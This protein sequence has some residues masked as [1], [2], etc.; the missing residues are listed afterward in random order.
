MSNVEHEGKEE[1]I[2]EKMNSNMKSEGIEVS[3]NRLGR[4][5]SPFCHEF[6]RRFDNISYDKLI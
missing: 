4:S 5:A 1:G 2:E 6:S 3:S